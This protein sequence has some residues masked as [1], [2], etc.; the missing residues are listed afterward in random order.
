MIQTAVDR[1]IARARRTPY[2]HLYHRDGSPYME[3][4]WLMPRRALQW[5][6]E[7]PQTDS[8]LRPAADELGLGF[9]LRSDIRHLPSWRLHHICTPD[10]DREFHNHPWS[11]V[12]IVLRGGYVERRPHYDEPR[13][14]LGANEEQSYTVTRLA[15]DVAF[16]SY[17][18]RHRIVHVLPDTW[19]LVIMGPKRQTWGFFTQSGFVGWRDFESAHNVEPVKA[20]A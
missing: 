15:G 17:R 2:F 12:S 11:F 19:T 5:I 18:D 6:D 14:Q 8:G 13:W 16:R 10:L 1:L 3:R 20:A 4:F 7:K 9:E